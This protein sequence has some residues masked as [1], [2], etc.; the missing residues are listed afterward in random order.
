MKLTSIFLSVT[1]L[2]VSSIA[3]VNAE[4]PPNIGS[5]D[6]ET[7]ECFTQ[8]LVGPPG[9]FLAFLD[10]THGV[11]YAKQGEGKVTYSNSKNGNRNLTCQGKR[12]VGDIVEGF[13]VTGPPPG[14]G[15]AWGTAVS[16]EVACDALRTYGV[17]D[18]ADACRGKGKGAIIVNSLIDDQQC[19]IGG[20]FTDNWHVV[21]N[22]GG[23]STLHCSGKE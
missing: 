1:V 15:S 14:P 21:Y 6:V 3:T 20:L 22:N 16:V 2:A 17:G 5:A 18:A 8:L 19:D 7:A 12:K 13:D 11:L 4:Q 10:G 23:V 9:N